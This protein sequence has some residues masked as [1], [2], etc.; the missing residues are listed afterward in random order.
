MRALP[1][2]TS[3]PR[4]PDPRSGGHRRGGQHRDRGTEGGPF[5]SVFRKGVQVNSRRAS[6]LQGDKLTGA[7]IARYD[8]KGPEMV[9]TLSIEGTRA[10]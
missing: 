5:E 7:T 2:M 1:M 10:L 9:A 8:V 4:R 3:R 6:V